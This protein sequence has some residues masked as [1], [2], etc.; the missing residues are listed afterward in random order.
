MAAVG[1]V[2]LLFDANE[3]QAQN[4]LARDGNILSLI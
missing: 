4:G 2:C 3:R 1:Q